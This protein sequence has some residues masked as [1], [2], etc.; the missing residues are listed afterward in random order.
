MEKFYAESAE[1]LRL[2]G[3][4][5]A[6]K[7]ARPGIVTLS[8]ELGAGKTTFVRGVLARLG[9]AGS[10]TSPTFVI[11]KQYD[12]SRSKNG[13]DRVYHVDA[14]RIGGED[15]RSIGWDEWRNDPGGLILFEW[16]ER[17]REFVGDAM[18]RISLS[19]EGEGRKMEIIGGQSR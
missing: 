7:Y 5:W 6:E 2:L 12:L 1:A 8:G 10:F 14:Y 19:I 15:L 9:A 17:A 18:T 11:M 4:E 3:E 16:P 13:I